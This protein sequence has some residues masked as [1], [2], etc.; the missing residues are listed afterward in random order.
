MLGQIVEIL[1]VKVSGVGDKPQKLKVYDIANPKY[2]AGEEVQN[3][4]PREGRLS[5]THA[6]EAR[7]AGTT[8]L[9]VPLVGH[10]LCPLLNQD[11]ID[12]LS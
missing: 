10:V 11:S 8:P 7:N 2:T 1:A 6:K 12:S 3:I 9:I 4:R 5:S